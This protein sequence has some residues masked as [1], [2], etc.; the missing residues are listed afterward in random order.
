MYEDNLSRRQRAAQRETAQQDDDDFMNDPEQLREGAQA[1]LDRADDLEAGRPVARRVPPQDPMQNGP[2]FGADDGPH[3]SAPLPAGNLR[4]FSNDR[5]GRESAF[6]AGQWVS[7]MF[8]GNPKAADWCADHINGF[9]FRNAASTSDNTKG[10]Y[11]VPTQ[12]SESI[13]DLAERYGVFRANAR[14]QPMTSDSITIPRRDGGVV[15]HYVA[16]NSAGTESDKNWNQV[17][18]T[19]KKLM[20][21]TRCSSEIVS[22]AVISIVDDLAEE[23]ARAFAEAE[24]DA[25]FNGDGTSTYGGIRGLIDIVENDSNLAG[26]VQAASGH[27][28]LAVV[29]LSDLMKVVGTL[30]QHASRNAAWICSQYGFATI[31]LALA[32]AGGG[33]TVATL[34]GAMR[35]SFLG[36]PVV[37]SQ[38]MPST[39]TLNGK[40]MLFF[41]DLR[42]A[43]T[44]GARR[45]IRFMADP[46]RYFEYDQ[47][48]IRATERYDIVNHDYG[49]SSNAGPVVALIGQSY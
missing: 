33:N 49:D 41:G 31:F 46:S 39:G 23:C 45:D 2:V 19:A 21:L 27:D 22:D 43:S 15:A 4:A 42:M 26:Y 25:G 35:P 20:V 29:T 40:V 13:I 36:Y 9:D 1:A 14:V 6:A 30:P 16:E 18:L 3:I 38:K 24:D 44:F 5:A 32:S 10:G 17:Q 34:S 28:S 7:A 37:V 48:A 47:I 11:L 8:T 12:L